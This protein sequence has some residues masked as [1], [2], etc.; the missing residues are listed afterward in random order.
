MQP[1]RPQN[2]RYNTLV[3]IILVCA[4]IVGMTAILLLANAFNAL[5]DPLGWI[6][7]SF[8]SLTLF[9]YIVDAWNR[10]IV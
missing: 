7:M 6:V 5:Y 1:K 2:K 4:T 9:M 8:L 3:A 10:L